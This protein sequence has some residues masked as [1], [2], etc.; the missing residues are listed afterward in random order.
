MRV[1]KLIVGSLMLG[2]RD[3][4]NHLMNASPGT[5]S[6][7]GPIERKGVQDLRVVVLVALPFVFPLASGPS[8]NAWQL[9][10]SWICASALMWMG[11]TSRPSKWLLSWLAVV[12]TVVL[13]AHSASL[14]LNLVLSAASTIAVICM[15]A[16]CG[17]GIARD[18]AL[19]QR[20]LAAGLLSAALVSVV[21][22]LLQYYGAAKLLVPW[23]T[24]PGV[25]QAYGN[26]RQRNQFASLLNLGVVSALWMYSGLTS[27]ARGWIGGG[28][29]FLMIGLAAS[30]SRTGLVELIVIVG[31]A[32]YMAHRERRRSSLSGDNAAFQLPSPAFFLVLIPFYFAAAWLLPL[33]IGGETEGMLARLREGSPIGHSRL[34]LWGNVLSLIAQHPWGG[35]GWGEL[36]YAHYTTLYRGPRF[37]EILDNA[38]NLPL[39]LA[40]ELGIPAAVLICGGFIWLVVSARPWRERDPCRLMAWGLLGVIVLHSLLEYPLWYGPFQM[41]FGVCLGLLWPDGAQV[42]ETKNLDAGWRRRFSGQRVPRSAAV[43]LIA[44]VL[45]VGWDYIRISQIYLPRDERLA[46]YEDNTLE[47]LR[48]SWL[49]ADQM[50]FAE[51]TL[52]PL[53]PSNAVRIHTLAKRMLHFSPEPRVIVKLI[54]SAELLGLD[55]EARFHAGRFRVAFPAEYAAWLAEEKETPPWARP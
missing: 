50:Q 5:A 16:C 53:T 51:L 2:G 30:A 34:L 20:A 43:L 46:A 52:T 6:L 1:P 36:S 44:I 40:V 23:T 29:L 12:A 54:E 55:D 21:L 41:I 3:G 33:L 31:L 35:W 8:V 47:K 7:V 11:A 28:I 42:R 9:M 18:G 24:E 49:F 17:A 19:A 25:G 15:A 4:Q 38:H 22:G 27:R 26:L 48:S 39:H 45:Y 32:T 37:V 10:A 13:L 14:G